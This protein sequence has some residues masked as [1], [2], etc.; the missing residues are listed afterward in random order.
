[1]IGEKSVNGRSEE[2]IP[3]QVEKCPFDPA[4]PTRPFS[5]KGLTKR[6]QPLK[7]VG[8]LFHPACPA[9]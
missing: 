3:V 9:A 1:M 7:Q 4:D 8:F 5:K 6:V 2:K